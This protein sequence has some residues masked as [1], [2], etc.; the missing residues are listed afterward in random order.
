MSK[1]RLLICSN[2]QTIFIRIYQA[3]NQQT[4][5]IF[6]RAN[7]YK[8]FK[9]DVVID[10][11]EQARLEMFYQM[12]DQM[13]D[14][15]IERIEA[16]IDNN[17]L[18]RTL[19]SKPIFQTKQDLFKVLEVNDY[20]YS[21]L[22]EPYE[23]LSNVYNPEYHDMSWY[24]RKIKNLRINELETNMNIDCEVDEVEIDSWCI[25]N[26]NPLT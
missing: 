5:E 21:K 8:L 16:F 1:T 14:F 3:I 24:A 22:S 25:L 6:K 13:P 23:Y 12:L 11:K 15:E 7:W 17:Q 19:A 10:V 4:L 9:L 26:I 18:I 20:G 2:K